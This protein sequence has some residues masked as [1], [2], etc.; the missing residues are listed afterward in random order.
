MKKR[1]ILVILSFL[2]ANAL[3]AETLYKV[4]PGIYL[5]GSS[6]ALDSIEKKEILDFVTVGVDLQVGYGFTLFD[7]ISLS[8]YFNMG[9]DT[10]LPNQPNIFYGG[11]AELLWGGGLLKYGIALGGG[12]L[13]NIDISIYNYETFYFRAAIPV[14]FLDLFK[15]S[16]CFDLYPDIGCRL[17]LLVHINTGVTR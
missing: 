5:G 14:I 17:G 4:C 3:S 15:T 12:Y 8:A 11:L 7:A 6:P 2:L 13:T 9:I 10:G 1:F 16:L